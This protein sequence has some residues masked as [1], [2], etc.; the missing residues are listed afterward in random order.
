M[1]LQAYAVALRIGIVDNGLTFPDAVQMNRQITNT[2]NFTTAKVVQWMWLGEITGTH[3]IP[4]HPCI[5][6]AN[7]ESYLD[8]L[9]IGYSLVKIACV[10]FRFWAK[11]KVTHHYLW[12]KYSEIFSAIEVG[13]E[14][15]VSELMDI[16]GKALEQGNYICIFPE[17]TRSRTG[18]LLPFKQG[19]LKLAS[20]F[21]LEIVPIYLEHTFDAW[22]PQKRLPHKKKCNVT[23]YPP[24]QIAKDTKRPDIERLNREIMGKYLKYRRK[25]IMV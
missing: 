9:L 4:G 2:I 25:S 17:G 23:F 14:S 12:K 5:L 3:N 18:E 15:S 20:T 8:F 16:S 11:P 10:P 24:I 22:P 7:H 1:S 13:K 19:Y 21:G 6:I